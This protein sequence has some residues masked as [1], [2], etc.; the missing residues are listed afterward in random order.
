[1]ST[2]HD[3]DIISQLEKVCLEEFPV[4]PLA[5]NE[6]YRLPPVSR[7]WEKDYAIEQ[8]KINEPGKQEKREYGLENMKKMEKMNSTNLEYIPNNLN[9]ENLKTDLPKT[10]VPTVVEYEV[11]L[12]ECL[13][14]TRTVRSCGTGYEDLKGIQERTNKVIR[15]V[16]EEEKKEKE[17]KIEMIDELL[18]GREEKKK[19]AFE[20]LME[21][22]AIDREK[23]ENNGI[24]L[25][26]GL[27]ND[28]ER[29]SPRSN[30][31][32][33]SS[34]DK[35]ASV[36]IDDWINEVSDKVLENKCDAMKSEIYSRLS[37]SVEFSDSEIVDYQVIHA[38]R[39]LTTK[40]DKIIS[41]KEKINFQRK[42]FIG[43]S[44]TIPISVNHFV[45]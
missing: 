26:L 35:I 39:N 19:D 7:L 16:K 37:S 14:G 29:T 34:G 36:L 43:A 18:K 11:V 9:K 4:R 13:K 38:L 10:V 33:E 24:E 41:K 44:K 22:Y 45:G 2:N 25:A 3:K 17:M 32:L 27:T 5:K 20:V 1:M 31:D 28:I 30:L 15:R 12:K 6:N 40:K 8:K 42:N 21:R 23:N